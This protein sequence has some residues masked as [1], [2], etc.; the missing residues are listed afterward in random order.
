MRC[1]VTAAGVRAVGPVGAGPTRSVP[2]C[3]VPSDEELVLAPPE[4]PLAASS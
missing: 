2:Y 4:A 1:D 3:R